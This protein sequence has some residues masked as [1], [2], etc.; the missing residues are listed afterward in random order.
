MKIDLQ[1]RL[2]K[3][4][5]KALP[6]RI[7]FYLYRFIKGYGTRY[8]YSIYTGR[9]ILWGAKEVK[10]MVV[11]VTVEEEEKRAAWGKDAERE[12]V[13]QQQRGRMTWWMEEQVRLLPRRCWLLT[14][15]LTLTAK[16]RVEVRRGIRDSS[17]EFLVDFFFFSETGRKR[18]KDPLQ[19][20]FI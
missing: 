12:Q 15:Q 5:A 4:S 19:I 18:S 13:A 9:C 16:A 20:Y 7:A 2:G 17:S 6:P 8:V 1:D 3:N 10:L 14:L 11:G